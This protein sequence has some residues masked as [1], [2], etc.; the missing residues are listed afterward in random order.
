M[1]AHNY[2]FG[3]LDHDYYGTDKI[4]KDMMKMPGWNHG[5]IILN[6]NVKYLCNKSSG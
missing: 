2:K 6:D 3:V 1:L 4:V 5:H